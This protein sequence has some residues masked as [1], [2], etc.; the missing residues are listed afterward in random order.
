M[1]T[2]RW[3][4]QATSQEF[5]W[6]QA[7][8]GTRGVIEAS[9]PGL[10]FVVVYVLTH[11]LVPTLV[12]A[13]AVALIACLIRL[14]QRQGVQ[15]ALSGFFGVAVGVVVAAA[16]G[17]GENYFA[18]GIATNVAMSAA[19]AVSVLARRSL[20][21]FFYAMATGLP[22]GWRADASQ[23]SLRRRCNALTWMWAWPSRHP[24]GPPARSPSSASPNSPW[25]CRSSRS[26]PGPPG[27]A[28]APT[29]RLPLIPPRRGT[30]PP[31]VAGRGPRR[32]RREP[33]AAARRRPRRRH[34]RWG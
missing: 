31:D 29:P 6:S 17:R 15:Q 27:G 1:P 2:P 3:M 25:G 8:G 23:R 34:P 22:T 26:A 14:I 13:L 19:F 20:V 21:G 11:A 30:R 18:W 16:T 33:G 12:A 32:S 10:V 28:C 9:A 24:C 7:L 5:S 4:S